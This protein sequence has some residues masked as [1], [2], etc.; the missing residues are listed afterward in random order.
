M[1]YVLGFFFAD[2]S[3]DISSRGSHYFSIQITDRPLLLRF[4]KAMASEHKIGVRERKVSTEKTQYRLQVG[5]KAM[6]ADLMQYGIVSVKA[7][8]MTFPTVPKK[9]RGDFVRGY[10]DGDGNVWSGLIHPQ[11]AKQSLNLQVAFTSC[12][13]SFLSGLRNM[14]R[15]E[16]LGLG[17]LYQ[18]KGAY[19]LQYSQKD[20]IILYRL[21][22][23]KKMLG[24]LYLPHKKNIFEEFIKQKKKQLRW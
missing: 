19:R 6:C 18:R 1:A 7:Q 24:D 23:G 10:F 22:Y 21:M 2:G 16:G 5:S 11:R 3:Y 20:S 12:S 14:L 4:K 13:N 9:Y 17:S 8:V 15:Q